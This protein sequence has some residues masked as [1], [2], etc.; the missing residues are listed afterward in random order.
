MSDIIHILPDS[1]ANQIAAGEVV[2]RPASVVKELVENS[3]DAGATKILVSVK[4][5]GKT[6]ILITDD[7]K[8]MS[9]TDSRM[10]FERH[11]TSKIRKSQD[12]FSLTTMGF[13]G[14]ALA[15]IAA[16][17]AVELK[18]R[19]STNELGT[20]IEIA[21]SSIIK[22]EHTSCPVGTSFL[23]K[24]LFFN[25]PARKKFLKA[26]K[27]ELSHIISEIQR[28]SLAN[29]HIAIEFYQEGQKVYN[30]PKANFKQRIV[31]I[32]GK[33]HRRFL[34]SLVPISVDTGIVRISGFVGSPQSATRQS[35]QFFFV[36]GRFMRHPYFNKA[37]L[38]AYENMLQPETVPMYFVN[39]EVN[40]ADIDVNVHP[41]KTEIKFENEKDIF[42]ILMSAV[43]ESL[44][45]FN[46]SPSLDFSLDTHIENSYSSSKNTCVEM[47]RVEVDSSYNPF[48]NNNSSAGGYTYKP[49]ATSNWDLLYEKQKQ[50]EETTYSPQAA[51]SMFEN[52][53]N[54][55]EQEHFFLYKQRF[56][57]TSVKSGLMVVD[58]ERA[59]CR[60]AYEKI[61]LQLQM[62][63]C[64]SQSLLFAESVSFVADEL[65]HFL[66][67]KPELEAL[68]FRFAQDGNDTFSIVGIPALLTDISSTKIFLLDLLQSVALPELAGREVY[69]RVALKMA[70][71]YARY[72]YKNTQRQEDMEALIASLFRQ[73]N[74]NISPDGKPIVRILKDQELL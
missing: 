66:E 4:D 11:A 43:R 39:F 23:V 52:D 25:V 64:A 37:V 6:S 34:D 3:I 44:G 29:P 60:I 73:N 31:D 16:V 20:F 24:N 35:P 7:G 71:E 28:V 59:T 58:I 5:G 8:G 30:L 53:V 48:K 42:L 47:P 57:L 21:A 40:P 65:L 74:P 72:A 55:I 51:E 46:F 26:T 10:A 36:N 15:S 32:F 2:Q 50:K 61:L 12:L 13:R 22:H 14:E 41:T 9:H 56:I 33:N 27:T 17:A 19:Q 70:S 67:I 69:E 63:Q 62:E 68:G 38:K 1:I 18:T 54:N 49:S 45:K